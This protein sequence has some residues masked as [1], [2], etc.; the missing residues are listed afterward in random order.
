MKQKEIIE[1]RTYNEKILKER[2]DQ[3]AGEQEIIETGTY[4]ENIL[5]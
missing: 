4:N 3:D 1:K 2:E 5:R